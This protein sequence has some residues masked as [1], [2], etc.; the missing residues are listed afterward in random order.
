MKFKRHRKW[1][2]L[3]LFFDNR[4]FLIQFTVSFTLYKTCPHK[5]QKKKKLTKICCQYLCCKTCP[6]K[7][8]RICSRGSCN[9]RQPT[10]YKVHTNIW[11][12]ITPTIFPKNRMQQLQNIKGINKLI[13]SNGRDNICIR[14][15]Q[16]KPA[17]TF[18]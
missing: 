12:H 10:T 11:T 8:Q 1:F 9:S 2:F 16:R 13:S 3:I 17:L 15:T 14:I 6:H 4:F 5:I 18:L 7:I